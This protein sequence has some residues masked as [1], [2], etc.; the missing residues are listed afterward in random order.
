MKSWCDLSWREKCKIKSGEVNSFSYLS[1]YTFDVK[2]KVQKGINEKEKNNG[3]KVS[4]DSSNG[5]F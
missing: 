1:G 3:V 4:T 5:S 2:T